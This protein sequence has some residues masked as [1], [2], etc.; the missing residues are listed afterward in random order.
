MKHARLAS[1]QFRLKLEQARS[2][3]VY[4][5][6]VAVPPTELRMVEP[7]ERVQCR[8]RCGR[9]ISPGQPC[10]LLIVKSLAVRVDGIAALVTPQ[11]AVKPRADVVQLVEQRHELVV[12]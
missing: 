7:E 10:H 3:S 2:G 1:G 6:H 12:E 4:S 8:V 9:E 5:D 11:V